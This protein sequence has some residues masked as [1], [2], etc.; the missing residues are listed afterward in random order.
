[1]TEDVAVVVAV[2]GDEVRRGRLED[3]VPPVAADRRVV[4]NVPF[5]AVVESCSV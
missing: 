4:L 5:T 2:P 1:M 3:G